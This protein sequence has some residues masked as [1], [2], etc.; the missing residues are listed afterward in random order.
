MAKVDPNL[1]STGRH[2]SA[3]P[4]PTGLGAVVPHRPGPAGATVAVI[5]CGGVG[6]NVIQGAPLAGR[7][8]IIAIDQVAAKLDLA[9]QFGATDVVNCGRGRRRGRGAASSPAD[10]VD[11]CL[12]SDRPQAHH[13]AGVRHAAPGRH[14]VVVGMIPLGTE[15]RD[16]RRRLHVREAAPRLAHGVQQLPHRHAPVRRAVHA[17]SDSSW[18]S[19]SR[20]RLRSKTSRRLRRDGAWFRRPQRH[21]LRLR[22]SLTC[23]PRDPDPR[24]EPDTFVETKGLKSARSRRAG[25]GEPLLLINGLGAASRAGNR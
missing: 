15:H 24:S 5:G 12:R 18:M 22:G 21:R 8:A 9:T 6:L 7:P 13:R 16:P 20:A 2:C 11:Y 23:P 4:S 17:G 25:S 1:P 10:G 3:V 14:A 19:S